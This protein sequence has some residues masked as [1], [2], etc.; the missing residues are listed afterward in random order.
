MPSDPSTKRKLNLFS[1]APPRHRETSSVAE[2]GGENPSLQQAAATLKARARL[3]PTHGCIPANRTYWPTS[4]C[5]IVPS[6]RLAI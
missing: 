3:H 1:V 5:R 4:I 2:G 6:V